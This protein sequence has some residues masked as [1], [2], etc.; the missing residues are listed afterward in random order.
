MPEQALGLKKYL[1]GTESVS[2]TADNEDT[3]A[4][5]GHSEVLSVQHSVGEPI[6]ELRQ[7]PEHGAHVPSASRR[8]EAGDVL[9]DSPGRLELV[10]DAGELIEEA[11]ARPVE[12][13]PP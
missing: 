6:P 10:E 8:Q 13:R 3:A 4:A 7:R 1:S 5:L 12:A 2:K 9:D 11:R